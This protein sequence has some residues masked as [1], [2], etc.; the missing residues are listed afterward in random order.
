VEVQPDEAAK[1]GVVGGDRPLHVLGDDGLHGGAR[2]ALETD[3][4][5]LRGTL[6]EHACNHEDDQEP[7]A[8]FAIEISGHELTLT[9]RATDPLFFTLYISR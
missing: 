4:E 1:D 6:Q 3:P 7:P 2:L 5:S 9:V 8:P